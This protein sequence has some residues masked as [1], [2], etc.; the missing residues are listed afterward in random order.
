MFTLKLYDRKGAELNLGDIVKIVDNHGRTT[1]FAEV[2]WLEKE[3]V[4]APF[5]TF[6]FNSFEKV[7]RL[8]E[9]VI[10]SS[11]QRY[12]IWYLDE[13]EQD[14]KFEHY[15]MSWRE[16]EHH[17]ETRCWRIELLTPETIAQ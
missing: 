17:L 3:Q 5:H 7:D 13:P 9:G 2:T 16:C 4:I 12:N 15:L 14:E 6:S 1:F 8:P 10:K 11:E